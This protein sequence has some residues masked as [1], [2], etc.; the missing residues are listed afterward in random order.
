MMYLSTECNTEFQLNNAKDDYE[1]LICP[2][3]NS[4]ARKEERK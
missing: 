3:C 1:Q 2:V 4:A